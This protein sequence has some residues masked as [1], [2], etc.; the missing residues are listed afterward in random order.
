MGSRVRDEKTART[1]SFSSI[2]ES[3][4]CLAES[5]HKLDVAH[6][7]RREAERKKNRKA[8]RIM[9]SSGNG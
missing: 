4:S 3:S 8:E 1:C 6:A 5:F 7:I 2:A 9:E